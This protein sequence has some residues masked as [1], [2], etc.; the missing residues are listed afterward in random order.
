MLLIN[1]GAWQC[2]LYGFANSKVFYSLIFVHGRVLFMDW[3]IP[4][5][6]LINFGAWQS[7]LY[8][9]ANSK[10]FCSLMWY[11]AEC[12]VWIC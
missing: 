7:A 9:F 6:L 1:F 10:V 12:S 11:M 3:L 5:K 4:S 2:A 8:G